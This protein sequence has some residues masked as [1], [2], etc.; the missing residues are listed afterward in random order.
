M[1]KLHYPNLSLLL[2]TTCSQ[3][4]DV[5]KAYLSILSTPVGLG[6]KEKK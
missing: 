1:T 5:L 3:Y 2:D 6:K 4:V